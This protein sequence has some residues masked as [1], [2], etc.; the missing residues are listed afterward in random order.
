MTPGARHRRLAGLAAIAAGTPLLALFF[1]PLEALGATTG[2]VCVWLAALSD[3]WTWPIGIANNLLYLW[4]FWGA[5]LYADA[6]LQVVFALISA[7]GIWR[8][9]GGR[10]GAVRPVRR[11]GTGE[12]ALTALLAA[13]AAVLLWRLLDLHTDSTV[14]GWDGATTAASLAAQWL[15]SRRVLAN[16]SLWIAVDLVYVPLYV[17]KELHATAGL[18]ALYL[19]LCLLGWR[20]WRR[21][22]RA[23]TPLGGTTG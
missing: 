19:V 16:W 21:E 6:L 18:Y 11:G 23:A 7:Y 4:I 15:M 22:L 17:Y 9:R 12:L 10:G 20:D 13:G 14:P 5:G 3:P 8:W 2:A 1:P